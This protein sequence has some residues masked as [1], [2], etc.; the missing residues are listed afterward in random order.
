M[1]QRILLAII[2]Y[3]FISPIAG[4]QEVDSLK[5]DLFSLYENASDQE[6]MFYL[7][8]VRRGGP[9]AHNKTINEKRLQAALKN[10]NYRVASLTAINMA[11][12]ELE[13][14]NTDKSISYFKTA[15]GARNEMED[16]L[17]AAIIKLQLGFVHYRKLEYIEAMQYF[18]EALNQLESNRL[19]R[20]IPAAQALIAQTFLVQKDFENANSSLSES[21]QWFFRC[22]R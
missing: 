14:D 11:W 20:P 22:R 9:L 13:N 16:P 2:L 8:Q 7:P 21:I 1:L 18:E 6:G 4:A 19:T 12:I 15:L 3:C 10:N 5:V 17:G